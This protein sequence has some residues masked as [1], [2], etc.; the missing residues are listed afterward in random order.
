MK[1]ASLLALTSAIKMN[2]P[3]TSCYLQGH[4]LVQVELEAYSK[5]NFDPTNGLVTGALVL[6]KDLKDV[7]SALG[8]SDADHKWGTHP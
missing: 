6:S 8:C 1:S 2:D 4:S 5:F 3:L 7:G